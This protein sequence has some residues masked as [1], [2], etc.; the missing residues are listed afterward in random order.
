[1]WRYLL[2]MSSG[3]EHIALK[4]LLALPTHLALEAEVG[5]NEHL[6]EASSPASNGEPCCKLLW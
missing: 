5:A 2:G 6:A 3:I 1:M 4:D